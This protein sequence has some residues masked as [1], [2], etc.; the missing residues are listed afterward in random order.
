M[1][2]ALDLEAYCRRIG[3]S[4]PCTPTL[5]TLSAVHLAHTGAIPFENLNPLLSRPVR[6][7]IEALQRKLVDER[8]GGYCFEQNLLLTHA[9]EAM[10][11]R[12]TGLA[13]RVMW[14]LPEGTL[15]PRSHM[16]LRVEI[17]G[18][19]SPAANDVPY[20][21][22][23]GFGGL[24]LTGPLRLVP[25]VE[26]STPHEPFRLLQVDG[27][28]VME[29]LV[30]GTWRPLYRFTLEPQQQVDYE[31]TNW[32]LGNHPESRFVNNLIAA[33]T[34][35]G[36]RHALL[37]A[38]LALHELH[39]PTTRRTLTTAREL[40]EVLESVFDISVPDGAEVDAALARVLGAV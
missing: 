34:E 16:L 8:R 19:E 28:W 14:M 4:G 12:V 29:G 37:N 38:A 17:P 24:T 33:R 30:A 6:L 18:G 21:A 3:Y 7:D 1:A 31:V 20:L 27:H 23:V 32:Y 2:G 40:R 10:G 11:F 5:A 15:M 9:L 13:A 22:D 39:G 26:Q 25:D 35:P 36:R